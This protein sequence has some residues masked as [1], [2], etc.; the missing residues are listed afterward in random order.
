MTESI[1]PSLADIS[2]PTDEVIDALLAGIVRVKRRAEIYE[3]DGVTPYNIPLWN[4]RLKEGS[5]TVDRTR[6]E[7]RI[8]EISLSNFDN[9]LV[10]NPY[11]G[12]YY[13]KVIKVFWGIRY[14]DSLGTEQVWD[15]QI[16]E[17]MIDRISETR[18]PH[19][20]KLQCRDYTKKCLQSKLPVSLT[21]AA[22]TPIETIIRALAANSGVT[23]FA[24][25]YTG[26]T[27]SLDIVFER[28]VERWAVMAK[29]ADSIGYEIY[30]RGDG[31]LT[32][33][34][35]PD[36]TLSPLSWARFRWRWPPRRRLTGSSR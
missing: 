17:F 34:P 31:C 13:D 5:V 29:V 4:G 9:A 23:K 16:G 19:V 8:A 35:Y 30:F 25:P 7:R 26:R 32:M 22:G 20:T 2:Y 28:G 21:F 15:T 27:Y 6:D 3:S 1:L 24:L 12:F 18:F 36:P 11:G 33:R 10:Q 14:F